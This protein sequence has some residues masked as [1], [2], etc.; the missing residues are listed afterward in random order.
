MAV[1][2][3]KTQFASGWDI[4]KIP[5]YSTPTDSYPA[6]VGIGLSYSIPGGLYPGTYTL[7]SI[8]NPYGTKCLTNLGWSLDG[9]AFYD[10]DDISQYYNST[11][12]ELLLQ[13]QVSCGCSNSTIYFSF[14]SA[15]TSTQTVYI[16]FA[17]DSIS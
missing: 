7:K 15:Y 2:P 14:L 4:D 13:M 1:D 12:R 17:I 11:N 6:S 9:I 16:Q 10:Q 3:T 5:A 8:P